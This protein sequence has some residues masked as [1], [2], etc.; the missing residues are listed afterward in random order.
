MG[1]AVVLKISVY[2]YIQLLVELEL[3]KVGKI[4]K[5]TWTVLF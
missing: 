4:C 5:K 2:E 3:S 1:E